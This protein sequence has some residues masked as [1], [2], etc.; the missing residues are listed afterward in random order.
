[1]ERMMRTSAAAVA[2]LAMSALLVAAPG[3]ATDSLSA[4][5]NI[6]LWEEGR[7]PLASGT[8][9]LDS[10]FL[11]VFLP[12]EGKRNGASVIIAPGGSN[13]MLMYGAEG[14]DIAERYNDWGVTAFV[15]TYRMSPRYADNA[16]VMDG[17]RAL[18]LVR[19]HAAEWKLDPDRIGYIGFSAGS[20]MGRLVAAAS[21]PGD[22]NASD[23]IDRVSSRPDYLALVYGAGR[24]TAGE[25]LKA[26]PATFLVSAA[27]DQGPS[28]GN[29]QLFMDLTKAGAVA[30]IHVYQKGRHGFGSGFGSPEFSGWMPALQ[31]FLEQG[32]FL[33]GGPKAGQKP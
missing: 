7:V 2:L 9:A 23:P 25:S 26:F 27:G 18:Q 32:G 31:H 3:P 11:T 13:I 20:N 6:R 15:L 30:E 4:Y 33:P 24:A 5:R 14:V 29:A 10:P 22:K 12:P 19:S 28:I 16:R 1:M 8:G 21:G 17:T